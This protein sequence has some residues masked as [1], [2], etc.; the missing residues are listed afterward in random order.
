ML[1]QA[2]LLNSTGPRRD[3]LRTEASWEYEVGGG[4]DAAKKTFRRGRPAGYRLLH[5]DEGEIVYGKYDGHDSFSL[6]FKFAPGGPS[7]T[8]VTV[9][10][11]S[12]PG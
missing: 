12:I 2:R 10:L 5:E 4:A 7:S 11:R 1:Q 3:G 6:T 9:L 8:R